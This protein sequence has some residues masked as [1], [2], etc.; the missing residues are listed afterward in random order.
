MDNLL[1]GGAMVYTFTVA[2]GGN[3]GNSLVE[4]DKVDLA[5]RLIE[6]GRR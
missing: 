4:A 5:K 3:V 2:Q 6:N 1:I